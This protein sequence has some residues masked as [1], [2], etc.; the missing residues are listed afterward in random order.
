MPMIQEEWSF[1]AED[2][3]EIQNRNGFTL[4]LVDVVQS[5]EYLQGVFCHSPTS[6]VR[7]DVDTCRD[8]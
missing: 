4:H 3:N 2:K 5:L 1:L 8:T 7:R 6:E